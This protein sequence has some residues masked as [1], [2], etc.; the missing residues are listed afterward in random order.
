M[1]QPHIEM[2]RPA[3]PWPEEKPED[4]TEHWQQDHCN[5]PNQ[6]PFVRYGAF[7][8]ND[9]RPDICSEYEGA[10]D[11]VVSQAHF[12]LPVSPKLLVH[13]HFWLSRF[14]RNDEW[15]FCFPPEV[16]LRARRVID[17]FSIDVERDRNDIGLIPDAMDHSARHGND[18]ANFAYFLADFPELGITR[19][20][21]VIR[22]LEEF[23]LLGAIHAPN[24]RPR[25][26]VVRRSA[27]VWK[28]AH[29]KDSQRGQASR[30]ANGPR[31]P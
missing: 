26:V 17:V 18:I 22:S 12:F 6:F 8:N 4:Q 27:S 28:P 20:G 30:A 15:R 29:R 11:A 23:V 21:P 5:D 1:A 7:E 9:N 10:Q 14:H 16:E 13:A 19:S 3:I 2:L 25:A 24:H 31:S